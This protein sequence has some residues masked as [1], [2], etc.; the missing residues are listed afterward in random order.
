MEN[1]EI[2]LSIC[3]PTYNRAS[4]LNKNLSS[5]VEEYGKVNNQIELIVSDN[6]SEDNTE[7]VVNYF[8]Q[9]GLPIKYIKNNLNIG[10]DKNFE[11]CYKVGKGKYILVLGDDDFIIKGKLPVL[12]DYL[13]SGDYGLVHLKT[14]SVSNLKYEKFTDS[15]KYLE[16][17]SIWITYITSNIVNSKSIK[18]YNFN[19]YN[20]TLLTIV[21]LY[22]NTVLECE[23]NLIINEKI[24]SDGV[25]QSGGFNF[26]EVFVQN[27]LKIWKDFNLNNSIS[28]KL[29]YNIKRDL[30][31][32]FLIP[33]VIGF[34]VDK[35]TLNYSLNGSFSYVLKH[36]SFNLYFYP[37]IV[38]ALLRILY[39]KHIKIFIKK[40]TFSNKNI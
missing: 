14:N 28:N 24:F 10:M 21:P 37:K 18:D 12:L 6:C 35:S 29:F 8:I 31:E 4:A 36:Y 39:H 1:L 16:N 27:Y 7:Q 26:F 15:E 30:F 9:N 2:L 40:K 22:I 20:G 3:I 33:S 25:E 23:E 5:I 19:K 17:I 11:Q 32:N 38:I 13:K 34:C